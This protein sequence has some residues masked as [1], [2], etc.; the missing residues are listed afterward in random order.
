MER[1]QWEYASLEVETR[2]SNITRL[3]EMGEE[4]W[5]LVCISTRLN[6]WVDRF[7]FKRPR[8]PTTTT[9]GEG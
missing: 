9:H 1:T 3:N 4:G 2:R 8:P 6:E 7:Y 5:E